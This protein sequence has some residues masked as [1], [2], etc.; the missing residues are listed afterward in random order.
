MRYLDGSFS[1]NEV[2]I[3]A[4]TKTKYVKVDGHDIKLQLVDTA[5]QERFR[6]LNGAF[7]HFP[8]LYKH[9]KLWLSC[10]SAMALA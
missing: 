10:A 1:E 7:P 2:T 3:G 4:D 9:Q 6:Y 5:G 8:S